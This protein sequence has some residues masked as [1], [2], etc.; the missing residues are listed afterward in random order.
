MELKLSGLRAIVPA[1]TKGIMRRVVE[2]LVDEGCNV[3]ICSRSEDSV[4]KTLRELSGG[5]GEVI[6]RACDVL[7]K[8]D[9]ESWIEE[10][11]V[12]MGGVDIFIP[13]VSAGGG[14]DSE[15]NWWKNFEVDVLSTVRGCETVIPHMQDSGGGAITFITTTASVETFGGPQAYNAMKGSLLVYA[16]QLSQEVGKDKIRVNCVSPGPIYFEGGSWEMLK[17]TMAKWFS[18]IERDHPEGR[19]GTPEEVANCI[20][21]ISSPAASWVSGT[22]MMVDGGFTKRVQF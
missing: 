7:D 1:S 18:K 9:Y 12:Q 19:L 16:K 5:R 2:Q 10:M 4:A 8:E 11:A 17:D 14:A 15:R 3:A 20:V 21:F 22:N 13:G 6:G